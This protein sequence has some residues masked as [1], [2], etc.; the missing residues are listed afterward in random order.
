MGQKERKIAI[1]G[2]GIT[3]LAAAYKLEQARAE[4]AQISYDLFEKSE[5]L[6]GKIQTKRVNGFVIELGPDSYLARKD[7]MTRLAK[8]VGLEKDLL[9]NTAGQAY[10]LKGETLYPI[11]GG[12][13]MGIPT[14]IKPFLQTNLLSPLGKL[15]AAGDFFYPRIT[16]R[17]EDIS[18]GHFFRRRLG[19]EVVDHLIEPLLSGIYAGN[20]DKLSLKAT[21]P[22]FQQVEQKHGSLIRGMKGPKTNPSQQPQT[23]T[24]KPKGMFVS[25]RRGLESLVEAIETKL[26][27]S[28][29]HKSCNLTKVVKQD[30]TFQ[31][32]FENG[33]T[34][35]YDD[36]II[37]TPPKVTAEL[38][39]DYPYF[40][41]L[42]DMDATTVATVAMAFK[43]D[44]VKNHK[45]GTGFVVSKKNNYSITACTWTHKKWAHSTP[46]GYALLRAYVGRAGDSA[47]VSRSD[48]E[49]LRAV[50]YDLKQIMTI[51]GDPEFYFIKR[52]Q[53]SM[54]QPNVGHTFK[55]AKIK[56]DMVRNLSGLYLAGGGYDGIGLPDCINQG[57]E[58]VEQILKKW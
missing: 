4:G 13:I 43:K 57:E 1:V 52:W 21:F 56:E 58:V 46:E 39:G 5:R 18:L 42:R 38:L 51:E 25:F 55:I 14:E 6:G 24:S 53:E 27:P 10:V 36:V 19:N 45:D 8:D 15:R 2:G 20:L 17:D 41:Y 12:A 32:Q 54:P 48:E 28:S 44:K 40:T 33:E 11:P 29:V 23:E 26:D 37:T 16:A 49:I 31:L 9:Y 30:G 35:T 50:L 34:A 7:S 22:Q 3:G 47:I